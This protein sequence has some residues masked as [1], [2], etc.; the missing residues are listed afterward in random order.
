MESKKFEIL[1]Y[2]S[3]IPNITESTH[4]EWNAFKN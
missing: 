2:L 3:K 4:D 1:K